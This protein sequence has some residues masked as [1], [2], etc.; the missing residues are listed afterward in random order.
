MAQAPAA[1]TAWATPHHLALALYRAGTGDHYQFVSA[2]GHAA[3]PYRFTESSGWYFAVG[4]FV[5]FGH[6]HNPV[7]P[8]QL[9][10]VLLIQ[11]AGVP[12][13]AENGDL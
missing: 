6:P 11:P 10:Q 7:H 8:V 3:R 2:D 12:F 4:L 9:G 13:G 5:G 1:F